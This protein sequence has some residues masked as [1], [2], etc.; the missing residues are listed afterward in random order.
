MTATHDFNKFWEEMRR[1]PGSTR[2]ALTPDDPRHPSRD[3]R[4]KDLE[5][6][7]WVKIEGW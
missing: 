6:N 4:Y 5:P 1:R 3:A 7:K 2:P